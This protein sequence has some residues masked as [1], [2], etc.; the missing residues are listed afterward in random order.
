MCPPVLLIVR[1]QA[2]NFHSMETS[3]CSIQNLY[4]SASV[5]SENS[6][7][8]EANTIII[9]ESRVLEGGGRRI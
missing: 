3:E 2:S 9:T 5:G 1:A 4:K 7:G 8:A 6:G